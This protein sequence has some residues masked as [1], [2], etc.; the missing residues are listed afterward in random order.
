[1]ILDK[2]EQEDLAQLL[3][4]V[5]EFIQQ[6]EKENTAVGMKLYDRCNDWLVKIGK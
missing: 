5:I 3:E 2:E 4:K 6:I 1:M